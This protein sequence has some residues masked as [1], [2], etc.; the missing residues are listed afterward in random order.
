MV[1]LYPTKNYVERIISNLKGDFISLFIS[2]LK[3][4]YEPAFWNSSEE[5]PDP[6]NIFLSGIS[7]VYNEGTIPS[8][9]YIPVSKLFKSLNSRGSPQ[10]GYITFCL[11]FKFRF[12]GI[13]TTAV[14]PYWDDE[15]QR[16]V[17]EIPMGGQEI[18][19]INAVEFDFVEENNT[20]TPL[21]FV[22]TPLIPI[23]NGTIADWDC[24]LR[25]IVLGVVES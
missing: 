11:L 17:I 7:T 1:Y 3:V 20:K 4:G 18:Q 10:E 9:A 19:N 12:K 15:I 21:F 5:L 6:P 22:S 8:T 14:P 23:S 24:E 25:H 16:L 13:L 2:W